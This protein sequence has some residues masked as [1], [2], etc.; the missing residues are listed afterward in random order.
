MSFQY[1]KK[2]VGDEVDF[3]YAGK[4]QSILQVDFNT[5]VIKVPCKVPYHY[6]WA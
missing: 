5:V 2:E 3:L 4:H 1:L 6:R